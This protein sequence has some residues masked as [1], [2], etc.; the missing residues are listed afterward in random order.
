[1]TVLLGPF[2]SR[3]SGAVPVPE[4]SSPGRGAC[5]ST[6]RR[7]DRRPVPAPRH[8]PSTPYLLACGVGVLCGGG[9]LPEWWWLGRAGVRSSAWRA[10]HGASALLD[11]RYARVSPTSRRRSSVTRG[12][13]CPA[14]LQAHLSLFA[15]RHGTDRCQHD[16]PASWVCG[17]DQFRAEVRGGSPCPRPQRLWCAAG[18]LSLP[19]ADRTSGGGGWVPFRLAG[20]SVSSLKWGVAFLRTDPPWWPDTSPRTRFV[21]L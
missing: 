7:P 14:G 3:H 17:Q 12:A 16:T 18:F 8:P 1:M 15:W 6:Q 13:G 5:T 21:P 9:G 19:S 4:R 2:I 11:R 10:G 20:R